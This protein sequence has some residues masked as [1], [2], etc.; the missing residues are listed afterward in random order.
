MLEIPVALEGDSVELNQNNNKN[1]ELSCQKYSMSKFLQFKSVF[2]EYQQL[3][4]KL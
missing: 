2:R 3:G 1:E 4:G